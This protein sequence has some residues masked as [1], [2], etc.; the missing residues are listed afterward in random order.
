MLT[1]YLAL[2]CVTARGVCLARI[3]NVKQRWSAAVVLFWY[4]LHC[5]VPHPYASQR[6]GHQKDLEEFAKEF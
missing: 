2:C 3:G 6:K 4:A 5:S 1:T